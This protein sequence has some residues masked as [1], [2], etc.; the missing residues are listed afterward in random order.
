MGKTMTQRVKP[1]RPLLP[2]IVAAIKE[3]GAPIILTSAMLATLEALD[4]IG[5]G[6]TTSALKQ[7]VDETQKAA[8]TIVR[9]YP[10]LAALIL[11]GTVPLYAAAECEVMLGRLAAMKVACDAVRAT[12]GH[13]WETEIEGLDCEGVEKMQVVDEHLSQLEAMFK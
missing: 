10:E 8:D 6:A 13:L 11:N 3:H 9:N 2:E 4:Q 5:D 12:F 1:N 7:W